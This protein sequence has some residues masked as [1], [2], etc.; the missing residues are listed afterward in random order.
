MRRGIDRLKELDYAVYGDNLIVPIILFDL[1]DW[2]QID[3]DA[4]AGICRIECRRR[5]P[6]RIR[7]TRT[8]GSQQSRNFRLFSFFFV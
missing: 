1:D 6:K 7:L 3:E 2:F 5:K 4:E 8:N